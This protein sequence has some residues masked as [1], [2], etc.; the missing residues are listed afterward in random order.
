MHRCLFS[1]ARTI[2][3]QRLIVGVGVALSIAGAA[4]ATPVLIGTTD[5]ATGIQGLVVDGQT[6]HVTFIFDTYNNVFTPGNPY[7]VS[8]TPIFA[9]NQSLADDA[10]DALLAALN[11]L[12]VITL[13]D[14]GSISAIIPSAPVVDGSYFSDQLVNFGDEPGAW[15]RDD[16][17]I[18]ADDTYGHND[19]AVFALDDVPE[20]TSLAL[21]GAG[22]ASLGFLRRRVRA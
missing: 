17:T 8:P 2:A 14:G 10:A 9:G 6:Y 20:P 19:I 12:G 22:L 15:V 16:T 4:M 1:P 7:S 21:L 5:N 13:A 11:S 3:V 18:N